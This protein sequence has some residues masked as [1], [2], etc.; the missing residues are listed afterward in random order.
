[1]T[2]QSKVTDHRGRSLGTEAAVG[3]IVTSRWSSSGV[4]WRVTAVIP[5]WNR[6]APVRLDLQCR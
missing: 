6:Y 3:D 1:M 4:R 5:P 2:Q